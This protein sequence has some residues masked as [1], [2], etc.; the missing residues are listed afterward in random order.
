MKI[1][2]DSDS[3]FAVGIVSIC[4]T[5]LIGILGGMVISASV[6]KCAIKAGLVQGQQPGQQ[7]HWV[8]PN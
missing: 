5:V 4:L 6:E 7:V 2:M 3:S 1:E 8:K